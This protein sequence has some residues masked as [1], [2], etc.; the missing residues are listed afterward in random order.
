MVGGYIPYV[1]WY[2]TGSRECIGSGERVVHVG[3]RTGENI[4]G[5]TEI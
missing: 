4:R 2:G 5:T 3:E 1:A